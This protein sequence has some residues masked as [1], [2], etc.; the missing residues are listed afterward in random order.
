M[1]HSAGGHLAFWIAGRHHVDP[2][3]ELA[4]PLP[5]VSLQGA[6]AL[7]G[8]VDLALTIELSGHGMFV[9]DQYNVFALMGGKPDE[10]PARYHAGDPGQ[11]LP[12]SVPQVLLQGSDDDQIPPQLPGRWVEK[13]HIVGDKAQAVMLPGADH[14]DLVDPESRAWPLVMKAV[15]E[16]LAVK[17]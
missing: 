13:A 3:G 16:M 11:L 14:L 5:T 1:G 12:F 17:G 2:K 15:R 6:I 4:I 9:R 8:A 7:A 10:V